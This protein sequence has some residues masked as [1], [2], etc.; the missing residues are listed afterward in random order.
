MKETVFYILISIKTADG[1]ESF[2]KFYIGNNR[3]FASTLFRRLKGRREV[4]ENS[5]LTFDLMETKD[6]LP[7]NMQLLSCSLDELTE[8]CK[9]ITKETFKLINLDAV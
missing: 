1:F 8:N 5:V 7:V 9:L 4:D 2:A 6:G 3:N